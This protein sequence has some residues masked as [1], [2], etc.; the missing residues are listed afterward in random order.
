MC[1]MMEEMRNEAAASAALESK[2]TTW[3]E[4]VQNIADRF[5]VSYEEV[6]DIL[7]IPAEYRTTVL[8]AIKAS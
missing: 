8:E 1:R 6:A 3:I 5:C 4:V 7:E 2:I